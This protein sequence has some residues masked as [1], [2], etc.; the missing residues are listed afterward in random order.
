MYYNWGKQVIIPWGIWV[1]E[2]IGVG[3]GTYHGVEDN[4]AWY[5]VAQEG[6]SDASWV[7][8]YLQGEG[9]NQVGMEGEI[10]YPK[11]EVGLMEVWWVLGERDLCP[12]L[13]MM[14]H[15]T[16]PGLNVFKA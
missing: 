2:S 6:L 12:S 1:I 14:K 9:V 16:S 11:I 5:G 4:G 13:S 7:G 10:L 8:N 15:P 3:M